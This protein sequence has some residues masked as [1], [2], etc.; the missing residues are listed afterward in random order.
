MILISIVNSSDSE[1]LPTL[2][3][4]YQ[5]KLILHSDSPVRSIHSHWQN[6]TLKEAH[7]GETRESF[8]S[9]IARRGMR[10]ICTGW[11][12]R[13]DY[14]QLHTFPNLDK[15][16][17]VFQPLN[18]S[19][20]DLS[21][22]F[23]GKY[24]LK[25][26][27]EYRERKNFVWLHYHSPAIFSEKQQQELQA[28]ISLFRRTASIAVLQI[29]E[30][31]PQ[32][33]FFSQKPW[34]PHH[35][36]LHSAMLW[37]NGIGSTPPSQT[38]VRGA[39]YESSVHAPYRQTLISSLLQRYNSKYPSIPVNTFLWNQGKWKFFDGLSGFSYQNL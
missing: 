18:S 14:F 38:L 32:A 19:K 30:A 6:L 24:A 34:L 23:V 15:G 1:I 20:S 12:D 7:Q 13:K 4:F 11:T 10:T 35:P 2:S 27:Q 26:Y 21:F 17:Q 9:K 37:L 16:C 31:S 33:Y 28:F 39:L 29:F 25:L 5:R 22:G 3:G 36:D 8:I